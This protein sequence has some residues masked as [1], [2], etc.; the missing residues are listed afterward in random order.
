MMDCLISAR[1]EV[2]VV[3][4]NPASGGMRAPNQIDVLSDCSSD[5]LAHQETVWHSSLVLVMD[6]K[7]SMDILVARKQ[8]WYSYYYCYIK[9]WYCYEECECPV[10]FLTIFLI[11]LLVTKSTTTSWAF[12]V[13]LLLKYHTI[14][15][16]EQLTNRWVV[17]FTKNQ[18]IQF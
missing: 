11:F 14:T 9:E 4:N 18:Q 15:I 1:N 10:I 7:L 2:V 12:Q 6:F 3:A 8:Q 5:G 17:D 16:I 13:P